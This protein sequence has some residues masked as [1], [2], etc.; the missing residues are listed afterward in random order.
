MIFIYAILNG[1]VT[2]LFIIIIIC[3]G[4]TIDSFYWSM[5]YSISSL[6]NFGADCC[7]S[8]SVEEKSIMVIQITLVSLNLN[9]L[10]AGKPPLSAENSTIQLA[11]NLGQLFKNYPLDFGFHL[12]Y[13]QYVT[14]VMK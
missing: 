7:E 8:L 5:F 2:I 14:I 13:F 12:F 9:K 1:I 3:N 6:S 11:R 10:K 4:I